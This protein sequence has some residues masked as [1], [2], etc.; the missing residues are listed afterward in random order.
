MVTHPPTASL[1]FLINSPANGAPS[2]RR[3]SVTVTPVYFNSPKRAKSWG[4]S[5]PMQTPGGY[6]L[7][8]NFRW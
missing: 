2:I 5:I 4:N 7:S 1:T 3:N 8:P 6:F